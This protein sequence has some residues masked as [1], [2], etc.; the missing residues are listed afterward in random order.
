MWVNLVVGGCTIE[1]SLAALPLTACV[2]ESLAGCSDICIAQVA[3]LGVGV[4]L[5]ACILQN[6]SVVSQILVGRIN[7]VVYISVGNSR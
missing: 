2:L 6:L 5:V 3:S 4:C 1:E 7:D